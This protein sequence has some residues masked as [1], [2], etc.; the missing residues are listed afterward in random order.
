MDLSPVKFLL[1]VTRSCRV[2]LVLRLVSPMECSACGASNPS[3]AEYCGT[4]GGSDRALPRVRQA[5]PCFSSERIGTIRWSRKASSFGCSISAIG[6]RGT[7][8]K[9]RPRSAGAPVRDPLP[10]EGPHAD[11]RRPAI[12]RE[13]DAEADAGVVRERGCRPRPR[14]GREG[15]PRTPRLW[16][17]ETWGQIPAQE[18]HSTKAGETSFCSTGRSKKLIPYL[19]VSERD[20][21]ALLPQAAFTAEPCSNRIA[22]SSAD[23][24]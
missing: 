5:C 10:L 15:R 19:D 18:A 8:P 23:V 17:T 22:K 14:R 21:L 7:L 4:R 12:G 3:G 1:L 2:K 24:S 20:S 9:H 11:P 13:E 6:C 16:G